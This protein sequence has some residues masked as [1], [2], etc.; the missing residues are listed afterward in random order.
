MKE[1]VIVTVDD[2]L[3]TPEY[4]TPL[5]NKQKARKAKNKV[6]KASRKKNR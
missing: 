5:T 2:V 4:V 3:N 6:A 1:P